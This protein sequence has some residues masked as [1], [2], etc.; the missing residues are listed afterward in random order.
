M[1]DSKG[2]HFEISDQ[3]M[4]YLEMNTAK[5][6]RSLEACKRYLSEAENEIKKLESDI[7]SEMRSFNMKAAAISSG[8]GAM[9]M[10][11]G[12]TLT[13]FLGNI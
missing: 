11:G 9:L 2:K 13:I 3:E 8:I 4:A 5:V 7:A 10:L 1:Y 12:G 6:N